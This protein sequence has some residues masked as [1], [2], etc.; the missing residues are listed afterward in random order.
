[1]GNL[2]NAYT[3]IG[4]YSEAI[5]FHKRRLKIAEDARDLAAKARA[6]GNLGNA[7][8]ALGDF[9]EAIK[10]YQQS[11]SVSKDGGNV[12][13][14]GQAHY[15]LGS[16]YSMQKN[17]VKAIE[18]HLAHVEIAKELGD[19]SGIL[20]GYYNLR[21]A[22]YALKEE[23]QA[24]KYHEL[25]RKINPKKDGDKDKK[26]SVSSSSGQRSSSSAAAPAAPGQRSSSS[27]GE[28]EKKASASSAQSSSSSARQGSSGG[29]ARGGSV[30]SA[31]SS[32]SRASDDA[33]TRVAKYQ[34]QEPAGKGKKKK[35]TKEKSVKAKKPSKAEKKESENAVMA[36]SISDSDSDSDSDDDL[37]MTRKNA[38]S[39]KRKKSI[40]L[41]REKPKGFAD[42]W[43][44]AA[45]D[46]VKNDD[47]TETTFD[48]EEPRKESMSLPSEDFFE[49]L[50]SVQ[51]E[52]LDMQRAMAPGGGGGGGSADEPMAGSKYANAAAGAPA[53]KAAVD[54]TVAVKPSKYGPGAGNVEQLD[55]IFD[56][57][58]AT[59]EKESKG[60]TNKLMEMQRSG[61]AG[62][63]DANFRADDI[64]DDMD[65]FEM[66]QAANLA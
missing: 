7:F 24:Q 2:G 63:A 54:P 49:M 16:T 8:S 46:Q 32:S 23:S 36:F 3:A 30:R 6:C 40:D 17:Y 34:D 14:Q 19:K 62:V 50:M 65:L 21:N 57:M 59:A 42:A 28:R 29:A 51:S 5:G 31:S 45:I 27:T 1:M 15:C 13:G 33:K 41:F 9:S 43:L 18:C 38:T 56:L 48:P 53:K 22:H 44:D 12:G 4:E 37:V 60:K 20:R 61:G 35:E 55:D 11:L 26:K 58:M 25:I 10:Y 52:G 47:F 66:L 39:S 64:D